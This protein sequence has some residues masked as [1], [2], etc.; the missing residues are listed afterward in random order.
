M[1]LAIDTATRLISLALHDGH[2][3]L[4]ETTWQSDN[5]H[6]TE[7][8][9]Q[10]ALLLRRARVAAGA[11]RGL[12]VAIGPG[13]YTGLRIGLG[14]AKGLALAQG[15]PLVGVPTL[16]GLMRAQPPH[17]G[18]ALA[19]LAAG[20]GRV[21]AV[22]Y[23]WHARHHRWEA[24]GPGR[25]LSWA[26]LAAELAAGAAG[27]GQ[28]AL[29]PASTYVAGEL[30]AAGLEALRPLRGLVVLASPA[31]IVRR[32]GFLAEIGWERLRAHSAGDDVARLA[33]QYGGA[34]AGLIEETPAAAALVPPP[35]A[36]QPPVPPAPEAAP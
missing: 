1:L 13:S 32:A 16:D 34:P 14:F 23:A 26:E 19:L 5:Y 15:L 30:D 29:P 36:D 22:P 12:A 25:G 7:L 24:A 28:P 3:V 35:A 31:H 20:R 18:P 6:T 9:P 17:P 10:T 8:A 27:P 2:A 21:T 4:A 33:P 11:L